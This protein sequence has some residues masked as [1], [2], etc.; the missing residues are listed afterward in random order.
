MGFILSTLENSHW[1]ACKSKYFHIRIAAVVLAEHWKATFA[2]FPPVS[3]TSMLLGAPFQYFTAT[4][5]P[6]GLLNSRDMHSG[7]F[8]NGMLHGYENEWKMS[9]SNEGKLQFIFCIR[10]Y[11]LS[12][13]MSLTMLL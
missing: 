5:N 9:V 13:L 3:H 6:R 4:N 10:K 2:H 12:D 11:S 7:Y 8:R 1:F